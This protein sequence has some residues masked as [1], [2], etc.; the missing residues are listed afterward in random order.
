M[1]HFG[2]ASL[3]GYRRQLYLGDEP[4]RVSPK[5]FQLLAILIEERPRALSKAELQERLWPDTFVTEGNLASL[6]AEL[7]SALRDDARNPKYI[8]TLHGFGYAFEAPVV[9]DRAVPESSA[10][11]PAVPEPAATDTVRQPV[12]RW[13]AGA[14]LVVV[15]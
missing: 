3:D 2:D 13:Y 9:D 11:A 12:M 1:V 10:P 4:L 8:R 7:R 15:I 6:I 14:L 5:A